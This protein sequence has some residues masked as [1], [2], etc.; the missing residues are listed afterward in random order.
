MIR[1]K[2]GASLLTGDPVEFIERVVEPA[3]DDRSFEAAV[4]RAQLATL[5]SHAQHS[6]GAR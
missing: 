5:M 4:A 3:A 1:K 6:R 2:T